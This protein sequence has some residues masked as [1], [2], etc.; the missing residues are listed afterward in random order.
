MKNVVYLG[1][2]L[3]MS[4]VLS[5]VSTMAATKVF[6]LGGQSNMAGY[7]VNAQLTPPY[8]ASPSN[9]KIWDS[10]TGQ[11]VALRGGFGGNADC[12]GPEL[13][14]GYA[15]H[16]TFPND[17]IFLVK[18]GADA[19][20]LAADWNPNGTGAQYNAFKSKAKAA[21]QSLSNANLSPTIA[22]MLWMQGETDARIESYA[23]NYGTN[24]KNL[25][26]AVRTDFNA[27]D[28]QFVVGRILTFWSQGGVQ[29]NTMVRTAQETVPGVVGERLMDQH[30]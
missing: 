19:T 25:I 1:V 15:I 20:S 4:L 12:F 23:I 27:P 13:S 6:F 10:G 9:V 7:G 26:T 28:M 29:W 30:R 8:D 2:V 18:H 24:L 5:S 14:F 22:G 11:W 17:N 3:V 16:S 21:L